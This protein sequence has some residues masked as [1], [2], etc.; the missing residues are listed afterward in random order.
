MFTLQGIGSYFVK[1]SDNKTD[2]FTFLADKIVQAPTSKHIIVTKHEHAI[3]K[4]TS[5][6]L[7]ELTTSQE[8][9]DTRM[10]LHA[11]HPAMSGAKRITLKAN[12]TDILVLAI[13]HFSTLQQYGLEELFLDFGKTTEL[14]KIIPIHDVA[15][16]LGL[17]LCKGLLFFHAFTGCDAVSGFR[18]K[19]KKSF[20]TTWKSNPDISALFSTLSDCP[21]D[22]TNADMESLEKFVV[23]T[24]NKQ[25]RTHR[26]NECRLD[27]FA[28]KNSPYDAIPP[29]FGALVQHV[30]RA[31]YIAGW[32]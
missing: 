19:G 30:R 6:D 3:S 21:Q 18:F 12:D 9:A 4:D 13:S 8:E 27:L 20:W 28:H 7:C 2:L 29:T 31:A 15:A 10:F 22:V 26:V 17:E 16:S 11:K 32:V 1:D 5:S 14:R 25:S 23:A 24:Y